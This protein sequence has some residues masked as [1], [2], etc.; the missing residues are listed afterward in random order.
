[1]QRQIANHTLI[2]IN[3]K[4]VFFILSF[5]TI[6]LTFLTLSFKLPVY[7]EVSEKS[8]LNV[9]SKESYNSLD[10]SLVESYNSKNDGSKDS[11]L[12]GNLVKNME[13]E[14]E[15]DEDFAFKKD[16]LQTVLGKDYLGSIPAFTKSQYIVQAGPSTELIGFSNSSITPGSEKILT[17]Q[18]FTLEFEEAPS[19]YLLDALRFYPEAEFGK[20]LSGNILTVTP[21]RLDRSTVYAFGLKSVTMCK[22]LEGVDCPNTES[23]EYRFEFKT[24]YQERIVYGKSVE[25]RDLVAYFFGNNDDR[26]VK[27][28][29]T[30]AI[31]GEEW[32]SGDLSRLVRYFQD[33]EWEMEGRNKSFVIVPDTN[34]DSSRI[35]RR[36]NSNGVNLNRNWPAY[37]EPGYNRGPYP[38]SEPEVKNL[39][40]L[41]LEEMPD[42]LISYHS[43]WAPYGIIF[44]GNEGYVETM[45]FCYWVSSK[46]GY[47]VGIYPYETIV[48][49]DQA[50]W[51]E[52]VGIRSMIIEATCK[53]C[54]DWDK[55]F[56]MYI[57]LIREF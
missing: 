35:D 10:L 22:A 23:W 38:L 33:N 53:K 16:S 48:A 51:A 21:E 47:P 7:S 54:T 43:Q 15:F 41:T 57:A 50:V 30:G 3:L 31:H 24:T 20:S 11:G 42:Y 19:Q 55:N 34:P 32:R 46:T 44:P 37:W 36:Y 25:G 2:N 56:P 29:L 28:M 1:M 14:S 18:S 9:F 8:Q 17:D 26:G 12:N 5:L 52:T 6:I 40:D 4:K 27:I 45:N 49:G 39:Y 13:N